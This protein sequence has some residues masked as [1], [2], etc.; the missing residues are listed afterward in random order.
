MPFHN[1]D[2]SL[3]M[4]IV[5]LFIRAGNWKQ[6]T[7]PSVEEWINKMWYIYKNNVKY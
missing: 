4:F 5:A 3:I 1:K 6:L 2:T 7:C